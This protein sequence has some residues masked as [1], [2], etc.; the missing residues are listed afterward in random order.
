VK[1]AILADTH[2]SNSLPYSKLDER[3]ISDR[4]RDVA[5]F[6]ARLM[7]T[8]P[9][10]VIHLGDV[11]DKR[12][13]DA[14][15]IKVVTAIFKR[16]R[17]KTRPVFI[18]PGNHDTEDAAGRHNSAQYLSVLGVDVLDAKKG[19]EL[20]GTVFH[21][22]PYLS[23]RAF[24][25]SVE[26][27]EPLKGKRN[28]AL[29]HQAVKGAR[30]GAVPFPS[31]VPPSIFEK[32]DLALG[33]HVH[34]KQ[35]I[36]N[37][38]FVGSTW[39]VDFREAGEAQGYHLLDT[40]TLE[41][42]FV[43]S[44][45]PR[46]RIY[47]GEP[48]KIGGE[49]YVIVRDPIGKMKPRGRLFVAKKTEEIEAER[50]RLEL[51]ADRFTWREA[52]ASYV[53][54]TASEDL[55]G[56]KLVELGVRLL[57][58]AGDRPGSIPG[59]IFF[60]EIEATNFEGFARLDP[61][62]LDVPG[63][64]LVV[65][66]NRDTT[67]ADSNGAGKSTIFNALSWALYGETVDG[68]DVLRIGA[69]RVEVKLRLDK[70]GDEYEIT[71]S[72][73]GKRSALALSMNG[74][75]LTAEGSMKGTQGRIN[76]LLG[77]DFV[78]FRNSVLFGQGDR[79]RFTDAS[80]KDEDRKRIFRAALDIDEAIKA[81]QREASS[82]KSKRAADLA[83]AQ[84][85]AAR[86]ADMISRDETRIEE[87]SERSERFESERAS[88]LKAI[89]TSIE[90]LEDG[91]ELREKEGRLRKLRDEALEKTADLEEVSGE[92]ARIDA[93]RS[94]YED[95]IRKLERARAK[96]EARIEGIEAEISRFDD[97]TCP[98]CGTPA[99]AKT[100]SEHIA[101]LRGEIGSLRAELA[102]EG[103]RIGEVEKRRSRDRERRSELQ[104]RLKAGL[105]ANR[106]AGT[107]DG[108]LRAL[109]AKIGHL[110]KEE[111][112]LR[113]DLAEVRGM[114]NPYLRDLDDTRADVEASRK[115]LGELRERERKAGAAVE[116]LDYWVRGF[117]NKGI[118]SYLVELFLP[119]LEAK[120]NRY[121]ETL[122]DGDIKIKLTATRETKKGTEVE[123]I[124][125]GF[126]IEG[127]DGARPSGGQRKRI[128]IATELAFGDILGERDGAEVAFMGIDEILDGL[129]AEGRARVMV[130]IDE[131]RRRKGSVVLVSH[132]AELRSS[133]DRVLM[134]LR[135]GGKATVSE[136]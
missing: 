91:D 78:S 118:A 69:K 90:D 51:D 24:I 75:D 67:A 82:Y 76:R 129:D 60:R 42:E 34:H 55:D 77:L 86:V 43:P 50:R 116:L 46:F 94:G 100:V 95:D 15:T 130:L 74:E 33:G 48:G 104:P 132:D 84:G 7:K 71:R 73:S 88:K 19:F 131:L 21:S 23:T 124:A 70:E 18:V 63:V 32:F 17:T 44:K 54:E 133:V 113:A 72:R 5:T 41:L 108:S 111:S 62:R 36:G 13:L 80:L 89:E 25:E 28:V 3:G 10:G 102:S 2:L 14:V 59:T 16:L 122:S 114:T 52:I 20:D 99:K 64:T 103:E 11:F 68:S 136:V 22:F 107:L 120:A 58:D 31:E 93:R 110:E 57:G 35:R 29:F 40:E 127:N 26:E 53:S 39:N 119:R 85:E 109:V 87:L 134:V 4:L 135:K 92:I 56:G 12:R 65:G 6:F 128:E 38:V 101:S 97:G 121:L 47:D 123:E 126:V 45:M 66:R 98:T 27:A 37:I 49:D 115:T 30:Q 105:K 125:V 83:K 81:A 8:D 9:P 112:R 61:L 106:T 1:L 79:M 96:T 117:G